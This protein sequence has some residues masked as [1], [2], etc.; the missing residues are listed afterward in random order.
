MPEMD[1]KPDDYRVQTRSGRWLARDDWRVAM[2]YAVIVAL[3]FIV[4]AW[5][6]RAELPLALLVGTIGVA[7]LLLGIAIGAW[8]RRFD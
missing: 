2:P 8:L 5:W 6:H 1:L 3:G 4:F 7:S